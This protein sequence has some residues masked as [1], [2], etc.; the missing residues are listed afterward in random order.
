ML[1][2]LEFNFIRSSDFILCSTLHLKKEFIS[3]YFLCA[4]ERKYMIE[5]NIRY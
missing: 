1:N 5:E 3:F 2:Q 4:V